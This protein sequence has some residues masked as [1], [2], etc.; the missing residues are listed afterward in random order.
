MRREAFISIFWGLLFV[1][2]DIR[3]GSIDWI[4]PDFIGYILIFKGLTSLAPEH[5]GFRTAR[6][7]AVVMVFLSLPSLVEM[8]SVPRD[9]AFLR[10]QFILGFTGDLS[11]L[12]PRKVNSAR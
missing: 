9:P 6:V 10:R 8:G 5:R 2:L 4:L 11:V 3:I 12:L 1:V 7:L